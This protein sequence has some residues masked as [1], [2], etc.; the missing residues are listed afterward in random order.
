LTI[1][2]FIVALG[3]ATTAS[4]WLERSEA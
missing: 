4:K 2:L 3:L 1:V